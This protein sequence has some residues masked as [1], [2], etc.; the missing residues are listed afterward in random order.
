[1]SGT[2]KTTINMLEDITAASNCRNTSVMSENNNAFFFGG[3]S[4]GVSFFNFFRFF[5]YCFY[6]FNYYAL[7]SKC[8]TAKLKAEMLIP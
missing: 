4:F 3:T 8:S 2:A 5:G 7:F 1:M 6:H